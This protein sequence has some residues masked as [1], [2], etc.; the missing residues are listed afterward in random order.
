MKA[1]SS[2]KYHLLD[3][4]CNHFTDELAM[5]LTG[6]GIPAHIKDLPQEL[7]NTFVYAVSSLCCLLNSIVHSAIACGLC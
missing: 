1:F 5:F 3:H 2:E 7:M 4:N 6:S